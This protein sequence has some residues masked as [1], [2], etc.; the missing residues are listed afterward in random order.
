MAHAMELTDG[1]L[2][3]V[4]AYRAAHARE[5]AAFDRRHARALEI[6]GLKAQGASHDDIARRFKRTN[7]RTVRARLATLPEVLAAY[8]A[9]PRATWPPLARRVIDAMDAE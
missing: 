7:A 9:R 8:R 2:A 1:E 6:A 4:K 5:W 3:A